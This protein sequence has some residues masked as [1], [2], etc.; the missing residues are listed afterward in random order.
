MQLEGAIAPVTNVDELTP[1]AAA[2]LARF[3][4]LARLWA[5]ERDPTAIARAPGAHG[6]FRITPTRMYFTNHEHG[7]G[8]REEVTL[9]RSPAA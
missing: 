1:I 2:Y 5:G 7:P 9:P 6:F 8:G 4:F 3:P